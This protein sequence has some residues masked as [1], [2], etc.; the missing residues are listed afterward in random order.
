MPSRIATVKLEF[1]TIHDNFRPGR[2]R[3]LYFPL[4]NDSTRSSQIQLANV[5][6]LQ[7]NNIV[8]DELVF[9]GQKYEFDRFPPSVYALIGRFV[10][11][12]L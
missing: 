10:W 3:N 8:V 6:D 2:K 12:G 11:F 7:G 1:F 4:L 5:Y 9:M